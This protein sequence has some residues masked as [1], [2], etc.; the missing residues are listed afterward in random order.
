MIIPKIHESFIQRPTE[1]GNVLC[2]E[3]Q[4]LSTMY[5]VPGIKYKVL[6]ARY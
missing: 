2:I 4:V 1:V 5:E 6:S 3:Y